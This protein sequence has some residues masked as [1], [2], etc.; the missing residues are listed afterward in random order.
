M[1]R[2]R[3]STRRAGKRP[4]PISASSH[5]RANRPWRGWGSAAGAALPFM[6]SRQLH[7][8]RQGGQSETM[9]VQRLFPRLR[10]P[11]R[12][13]ADT[14]SPYADVVRAG[15][16]IYLS[17][18]GGA[19]QDGKVGAPGDAVAQT[20]DALDRLERALTA[21]GAS[22][23]DIT[24]LTTS[25]IDRDH[26]KDVY[27]TINRRLHNV[28]PVSTG[29]IVAGLPAPEM[30]V[31]ID[32]EAICPAA[33]AAP[34]RRYRNYDYPNWHGQ[35]FSW[36][37]CMV[38]AGASELFVRGQTG[39]RLDGTGTVGL[40]RRPED[41]AAQADLALSNLGVLLKEAGSGL[42]EVAKITVYISDRAYRA[43]VYPVI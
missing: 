14:P 28:Y 37:G 5:N 16:R 40:G 1:R 20:N 34:V 22:L 17:A 35:N 33:G 26:R 10:A 24:K 21:A 27:G 30:V 8:S 2:P 38:A 41:A 18:Q 15:E 29:L 36:Q 23:A 12:P 7:S 42:D 13:G 6:R 31:Q 43:A 3:S 4:S 11:Y 19:G 39:S 25:L 9:T 32:A